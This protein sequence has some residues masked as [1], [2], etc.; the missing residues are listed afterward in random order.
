[1]GSSRPRCAVIGLCVVLL[2]ACGSS[3][4][5]VAVDG[6]TGPAP[7]GGVVDSTDGAQGSIAPTAPDGLASPLARWGDGRALLA[8][9]DPVGRRTVVVTTVGISLHGDDGTVQQI[10]GDLAERPGRMAVTADGTL[11]AVAGEVS[12]TVTAWDLTS[13]QPIG[14]PFTTD[15]PVSGLEFVPD[16]SAVV[17]STATS[18]TRV[19][20]D[21]TGP[22]VLVDSIAGSLGSA[23]IAPDG[24]WIVAPVASDSGVQIAVWRAGELSTVDLPLADGANAR[25]AVASPGGTYVGVVAEM[26]DNPFEARLAIWDVTAGT[27][28]GTVPLPG[29]A[30]SV[31]AFGQDDRVVVSDGAATTLWTAAGEELSMLDLPAEVALWSVAGIGSRPG[32]VSVLQ[33]GTI[34][35]WDGEGGRLASIGDEGT[36]LVDVAVAPDGD[37]VT[38]VDFFGAVRRWPIASVAATDQEAEQ[39][40]VGAVGVVNSVAF[41]PD[42][43]AVAL[44]TSSGRVET[45][46]ADGAVI[47]AFEQ[48]PGNVDSV[49]YAPD[50]ATLASAMGERRGPES[51]DDTVTVYD[52][53]SGGTAAQ[54]GGEAEQVAGCA[55]FRNEV[56][57]SPDGRLLAANSHDFT[58]SLYD[59]ADGH[60]L[61]TFPAHASTVTDLAFSPDGGLL[62]TSSDDS[63]VRVWSVADRRLTNEFSAPAG[64]YWSLVFSGDGS[65][66]VVADLSGV[67]S[68]LDVATGSVVRTFAGHKDRLAELAISPDG[69]LV[70][71]GG[72]DNS[73]ELWS[74]ASGDLVAQLPGHTAP[75]KTVAFSPDGSMLASGSNDSTV[76]LWALQG[77]S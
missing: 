3:N 69:S 28:A 17:V 18:I 8:R 43:S 54:F 40:V 67:V 49:A 46:D 32:F 70:A 22:S 74:T 39:V 77:T 21:G 25:H 20:L 75:V 14:V 19:P 57:F 6:G 37:T 11:L 47:R 29:G 7:D 26:R 12:G 62:A 48:P 68:V 16:G 31:W 51:F 58:V 10:G 35:V 24:S 71:S 4:E 53:G 5:P 52:A 59:P 9:Y 60:I 15:G 64:G 73:V 63:T 23:T 44:A 33:D 38:T 61:H 66:L 13:Q 36:T 50:S 42:G 65:S 27:L 2:A 1:M 56:R 76:R 72:D 45:I 41:A 34:D 30:E 55:F